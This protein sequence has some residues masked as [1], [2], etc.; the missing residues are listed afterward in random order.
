LVIAALIIAVEFEHTP[1]PCFGDEYVTA[2]SPHILCAQEGVTHAVVV[3]VVVIII[4]V[5]IVIVV[6]CVQ[7]T[8]TSGETSIGSKQEVAAAGGTHK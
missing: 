3:L 8:R 5:V 6:I 7:T 2:Q 1:L 4:V